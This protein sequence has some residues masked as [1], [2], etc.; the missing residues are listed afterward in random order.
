[1]KNEMKK[2]R[3][4]KEYPYCAPEGN[5]FHL[6]AG[7]VSYFSG[8]RYYFA[9]CG[10]NQKYVENNPDW[11]EE[12]VED[13]TQMIGSDDVELC[14]ALLKSIRS[15]RFTEEDMIEFAKCCFDMERQRYVCHQC[16]NKEGYFDRIY[17][18]TGI[19][20]RFEEWK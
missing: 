6:R 8:G 17:L 12:V 5:M 20:E 11:F 16:G 14:K 1:M 9:G 18:A 7:E 10:F 2:Y 4:L 15:Y 3:L 13:E 19:K